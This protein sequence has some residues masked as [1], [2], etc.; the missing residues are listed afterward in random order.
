MV[1][2]R[3]F[4]VVNLRFHF[5][6]FIAWKFQNV[7]YQRLQNCFRDFLA[8]AVPLALILICTAVPSDRSIAGNP[9]ICLTAEGAPYF[10]CK[11]APLGLGAILTPFSM[12]T[13]NLLRGLKGRF[14][15]DRRVRFRRV[16]LGKLSFIGHLT[17]AQMVTN[18]GFLQQRVPCVFF[19][20]ENVTDMGAAEGLTQ[21]AGLALRVE[22]P[23]YGAIGLDQLSEGD[24]AVIRMKYFEK[25]PDHEIAKALGMQEVS[26]RS[27]LTRARK[28]IFELLGGY[29]GEKRQ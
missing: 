13:D 5:R 2:S 19:I 14:V 27:K 6:G 29:R 18:E 28:R 1:V 15:D 8:M 7:S 24:Q 22:P 26:V 20:S 3:Y 11:L 25:L 16:V 10:R 23:A 9:L 12:L 21:R 4:D 17:L